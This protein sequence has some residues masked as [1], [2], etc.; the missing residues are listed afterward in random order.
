MLHI[1]RSLI[2]TAGIATLSGCS[3]FSPVKV[4]DTTNYE[5]NRVPHYVKQKK[6]KNIVI[7]VPTPASVPAYNTRDMAYSIKPHQLA[8]FARNRWI[9]TPANMIGQLIAQS[10]VNTH[11]YKAVVTPPLSGKYDF[12][13][14]SELLILQ[15][16]FT[17]RPAQS[18][19]KLRAN[20]IKASTN[21]I[22]ASRDFII[23]QAFYCHTPYN[24]VMA[25]NQ[26]VVRALN[27]IVYF[28]L[29]YT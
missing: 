24:G 1:Y 26:A 8:Y 18:R 4:N 15:Q 6:K 22:I 13:F 29:R 12:V 14:S 19:F 2:L 21:Q 3:L 28:A 27:E 10:L 25:T 16:D 23:N 20:I 17:H 9:E 5:I 7:L 11:H